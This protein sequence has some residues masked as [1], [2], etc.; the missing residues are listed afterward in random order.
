MQDIRFLW[1]KKFEI[2]HYGPLSNLKGI[3]REIYAGVFIRS[4]SSL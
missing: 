3:K 4:A 2:V 1:E